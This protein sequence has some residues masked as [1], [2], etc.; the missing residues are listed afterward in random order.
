MANVVLSAEIQANM[1]N[2]VRNITAAASS[3][4]RLTNSVTGTTNAIS[5]TV[6]AANAA[7]NGMAGFTKTISTLERQLSTFREGLRNTLDPARITTLN[8]AIE[9]TSRRLTETNRAINSVNLSR[10]SVGANQ[11]GNALTNLGRVAQD[12]PFGFIGIQ[13]NLNPLLES[14]TR[15]RQETG[16]NAAALR[17]LGQSFIG[18]AGLGVALSLVTAAFTFYTMWQ[19]RSNKATKEAKT[20]TD[21]YINSLNQLDQVKVKGAQN[22]QKELTELR[23]LYNVSQD[24]T[25]SYKQRVDAVNELQSKYPEY[26]KNIKDESILAGN[27]S[28]AYD[29][30]ANSILATAR[31]RAAQDLITKN[32]SKQL[33][34][35]QKIIDLREKQLGIEARIR[36]ARNAN[37]I[38]PGSGGVAQANGSSEISKQTTLN[39]LNEELE[40]NILSQMELKMGISGLNQKNLQ[41]EKAITEQI[42]QGAD[43]TGKVGK[44]Q[45][46]DIDKIAEIYKNL[47]N[48]LKKNPLA[49]GADKFSIAEANISSYQTAINGLIDNGYKPASTAV[50]DLID[51]QNKLTDAL[52]YGG[53]NLQA[54]PAANLPALPGIS[55]SQFRMVPPAVLKGLTEYERLI[56]AADAST[57]KFYSSISE[58]ATSGF[59]EAIGSAFSSIG[60]ALA[61]G[62]SAIDAFGSAIIQAFAGFL[63]QLGQM[64]IKEGVAQI[65]YGIAKNLILPG[66]GANNIAGGAGMIA[67]GAA[68]SV[69][70]GLASGAKG[71]GGNSH[72]P[73]NQ[74]PQFATGVN[75]FKGGMAL[76]GERGPEL[77]NLPTGADVMTN[78]RTR[79]IM[80]SAQNQPVIISSELGIEMGVLVAKIRTEERRLNR[81]G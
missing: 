49:F 36:E 56:L 3:S 17:A 54:N 18:P 60:V 43:I 21:A 33:E 37:Y 23:T 71:R 7:S 45:A 39:V 2:F 29:K 64:F 6:G 16:S 22:A 14:F 44:E 10:F 58:L 63:G 25:L 31:A 51:K 24:V 42:K 55:D 59:G 28:T 69:L 19:Q 66:S 35:E 80:G 53:Q 47:A 11:A 15:L 74:I 81:L 40:K 73:V 27:A 46:K 26:F 76:V 1:D 4:D 52:Q 62:T 34:E 48:D 72:T 77:V 78:T 13:N 20:D 50:Q 67:A 68:I 9:I 38:V 79:S 70:G 30:L 61:E 57:E 12:A 65:G 32:A 8:S 5:Q 75:N 41:L